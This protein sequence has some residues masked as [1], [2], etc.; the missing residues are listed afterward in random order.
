MQK[1]IKVRKDFF[2]KRMKEFPKPQ[3]TGASTGN[4]KKGATISLTPSG[5]KIRKGMKDITLNVK[6][7]EERAKAKAEQTAKAPERKRKVEKPVSFERKERNF[8]DSPFRQ[9]IDK[10]KGVGAAS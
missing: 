1:Q 4:L 9:L 3:N 7:A 2:E 10:L 6:K 8:S 5:K